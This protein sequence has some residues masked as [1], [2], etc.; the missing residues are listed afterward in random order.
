MI[1]TWKIKSRLVSSWQL[2]H[3]LFHFSDQVEFMLR[4]QLFNKRTFQ[5]NTDFTNKIKSIQTLNAPIN[6]FWM[7]NTN[8]NDDKAFLKILE[9]HDLFLIT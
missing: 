4:F 1:Y 7:E 6:L 2:L 8:L 3:S 5:Q 9:Y